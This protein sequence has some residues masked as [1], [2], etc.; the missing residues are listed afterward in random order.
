MFKELIILKKT[1]IRS[2]LKNFRIAFI[3][4]KN[5]KWILIHIISI[6]KIDNFFYIC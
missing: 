5:K 6:K 4:N 3:K 1:K 2:I